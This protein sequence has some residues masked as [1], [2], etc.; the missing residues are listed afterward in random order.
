MVE[1]AAG[2]R[3]VVT[4][5]A[6]RPHL[7]AVLGRATIVM[8]LTADGAQDSRHFL[9]RL[10]ARPYGPYSSL[11]DSTVVAVA[12]N[13]PTAPSSPKPARVT[14]IEELPSMWFM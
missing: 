8:Q 14:S 2:E 3:P 9:A 6:F 1:R 13:T 7:G 12:P 4:E 10:W 11:S 5:A